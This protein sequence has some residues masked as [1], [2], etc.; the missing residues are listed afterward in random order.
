MKRFNV[1]TFNSDV[2]TNKQILYS[3][4]GANTSLYVNELKFALNDYI[5]IYPTITML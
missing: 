3:Y 5:P 2:T 4:T 1:R